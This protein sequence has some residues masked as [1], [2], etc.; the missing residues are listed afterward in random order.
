[1]GGLEWWSGEKRGS[2]WGPG[3]GSDKEPVRGFIF[4]E[5]DF[6]KLI[7]ACAGPDEFAT[8]IGEADV[9]WH[10]WEFRQWR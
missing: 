4:D 7:D 2:F 5:L 10:G 3:N 1:M 9:F 6:H 8:R